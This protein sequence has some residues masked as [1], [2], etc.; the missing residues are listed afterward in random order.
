MS[1]FTG[2]MY[3]KFD[4]YREKFFRVPKVFTT[5]EKY[6]SMSND[7]KFGYAILL[8]RQ[9]LS[10]KNG[11]T[12]EEGNIYFVFSNKQLC[13]IWNCSEKTVIKIKNVLKKAELLLEVR[14]GRANHMYL[15]RPEVNENDIYLIDSMEEPLAEA[16]EELAEENCNFYSSDDRTVKITVQNRKKYSSELENLQPNDTELINTDFKEILKRE[17]NLVPE[18]NSLL[19]SIS[20]M[21]NNRNKIFND[22]NEQGIKEIQYFYLKNSLSKSL[23]SEILTE[24]ISYSSKI[25]K[26]GGFLISTKD[27]IEKRKSKQKQTNKSKKVYK[28]KE[29]KRKE[30]MLDSSVKEIPIESAEERAAR[31]KKMLDMLNA[32]EN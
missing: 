19:N 4:T 22:I 11:W 27:R 2:R 15:L 21:I 9:E 29:N 12:D 26:L 1:N 23:M 8:D 28:S 3:N 6:L 10:I 20:S 31:K 14:T 32:N 18:L 5:N 17:R 30:L 7:A 16:P 13:K 25:D 24:V